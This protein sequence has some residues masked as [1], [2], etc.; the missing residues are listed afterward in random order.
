MTLGPCL[1]QEAKP[2]ESSGPAGRQLREGGGHAPKQWSLVITGELPGAQACR[3]MGA[4]EALL[5][6]L[7]AVRHLVLSQETDVD[8][9]MGI[10][11]T[12]T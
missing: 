12:W 1:D 10:Y 2:Q 6:V 7:A 11:R 3:L 4:P 5:W 9:G 8:L